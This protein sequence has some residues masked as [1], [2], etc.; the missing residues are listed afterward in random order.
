[1]GEMDVLFLSSWGWVGAKGRYRKL[2]GNLDRAIFALLV[3]GLKKKN[4]KV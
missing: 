3:V 1:M 4:R 2:I